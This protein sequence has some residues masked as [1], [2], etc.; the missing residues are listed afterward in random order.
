MD[1]L[2]TKIMKDGSIDVHYIIQFFINSIHLIIIYLILNK[3]LILI[4]RVLIGFINEFNLKSDHLLEKLRK[5]SDGKT[6][7]SMMDEFS[8]TA[9]DVISHVALGMV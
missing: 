4:K 9:L 5:Y 1:L 8:R 3:K 7:L 6:S 2:Q